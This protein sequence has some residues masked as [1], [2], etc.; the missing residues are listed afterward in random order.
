MYPPAGSIVCE[1]HATGSTAGGYSTHGGGSAEHLY[2]FTLDTPQLVQFDS[3]ASSYDTYLRVM[4]NDMREELA[5]CDD[6]G[7]CGTRTILDADLAAGT[8]TLLIEGFA[9]QEGEYDVVMHCPTEV[10]PEDPTQVLFND[11]DVSC[12]TTVNGN[13]VGSANMLGNGGGDHRYSFTLPQGRHVLQFDSCA[14]TFDTYLR[15]FNG[16]L[17]TEFAGCDDCG[18]CGL[19]TVLDAILQCDEVTSANSQRQPT[20]LSQTLRL[21]VPVR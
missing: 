15:V 3:C 16:D 7:T 17:T 21:I 8:Y 5:G 2:T 6:C 18:T 10:D 9:T 4:S 19:Q 20:M 14:S 12:G 11:G 13:T 1:Q